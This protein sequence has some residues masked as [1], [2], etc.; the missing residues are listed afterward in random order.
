MCD[1]NIKIIYIF[2]IFRDDILVNFYGN[3]WSASLNVVKYY[4]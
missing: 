3:N 1:E 4:Y 2:L